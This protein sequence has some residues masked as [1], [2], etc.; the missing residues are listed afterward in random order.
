MS[1]ET[2]WYN[3]KADEEDVILSTRVRLSRNLASFPFPSNFKNDDSLRVQNI[4][5]DAFS[6]IENPDSYQIMSLEKIK[7]NG[8]KILKERGFYSRRKGSGFIT[9]VEGDLGC[10]I[11]ENDHIKISGFS[12]G[13]NL[14]SA[15]DKCKK[16]DNQLQE[17]IQYAASKD[18]GF[19]NSSVFNTGSGM[20][21]NLRLHLPSLSYSGEIRDLIKDVQKKGF[22]FS[23]CFGV[24]NFFNS[25]VG[26]YYE[27][28][29]NSCL[30]GNEIDQL[31]NVLSI[32]KY[33]CDFERKKRLFYADNK[34]TIVRNIVVRA[35]SMAKFSIL[36]PL[37]ECIEIIS[38]LK[39]GLDLGII[40]GIAD[41]ELNSLLYSIQSGHL[42]YLENNSAVNFEDDILEDESL[43]EDRLRSIVI[44][45]EVE[46]I[47]FVSK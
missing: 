32:A 29:T 6:R 38:C 19:L 31:A 12:A 26:A 2:I 10:L 23:D 1:T 43:K 27:L 4:I 14:N 36:L 16:L 24:G 13:L 7:I 15:F 40:E 44:K 25:S 28:S 45:P 47:K 8:E 30:K 9:T 21:V 11:N 22:I 42:E 34:P 3:N 18:F 41:Y 5:F 35:Y 37:R 39:W 20:K 46:K 33:I 17:F